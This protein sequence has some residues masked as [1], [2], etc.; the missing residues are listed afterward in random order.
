MVESRQDQHSK[1][2]Q[3]MFWKNEN[4]ILSKGAI[5]P[6]MGVVRLF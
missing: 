1:K 4:I 3:L 2:D 6:T 5:T